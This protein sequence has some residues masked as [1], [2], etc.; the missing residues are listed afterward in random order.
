[1]VNYLLTTQDGWFLLQVLAVLVPVLLFIW[2]ILTVTA[3][4][5]RDVYFWSLGSTWTTV[6]VCLIALA[7]VSLSSLSTLNDPNAPFL[8][9]PILAGSILYAA[10][11]AYAIFYNYNTTKSAIL[12][13][14]TSLLQQLAVLGAIFLF[15]RWR[16]NEVNR[17]R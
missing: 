10:A 16:G 4:H 6:V 5:K 9:A 7:V 17:G 1:M 8:R 13:I 15:L 2:I 11:F 12:A 3:L 14:S